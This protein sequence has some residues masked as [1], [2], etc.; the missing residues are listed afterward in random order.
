MSTIDLGLLLN[1]LDRR[2]HRSAGSADAAP[3]RVVL[4][5]GEALRLPA[6][7]TRVAILTGTA[8]VTQR[9]EDRI[10]MAG[11]TMTAAANADCAVVSALGT[12]PLLLEVR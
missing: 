2:A 3:L 12:V 4:M 10:L 5:E 9:G 6:S 8:W 7:R 1:G 11:E